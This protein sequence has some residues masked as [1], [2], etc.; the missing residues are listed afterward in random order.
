MT[1]NSAQGSH[2]GLALTAFLLVTVLLWPAAANAQ[3]P[4]P[5]PRP[6]EIEPAVNFW[7]KVY[8][9]INTRNGYLHDA[10]NLSVIYE[11]VPYNQRAISNARERIRDDLGELGGGKRT[12]LTLSQREILALFP[13]DVSNQTLRAAA[14]DLRFQLGRPTGSWRLQRSGAYPR[15]YP[16]G[17]RGK[18]SAAE[19]ASFPTWSHRSILRGSPALPAFRHVAVRPRHRPT[20]HAYRP[21]RDERMDP[22]IA[23]NAAMSLLEYNYRVTHWPLA[24]PPTTMARAA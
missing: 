13:E 4:D 14:W 24:L 16:S 15:A 7:L 3:S 21:H 18:G 19:S 20:L 2:R 12:E 23:T 5:F 1:S 8:T 17:H 22:S 10:R 6:P 9:E 11:T